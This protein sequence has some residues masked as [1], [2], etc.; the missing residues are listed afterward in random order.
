M[1][2]TGEFTEKEKGKFL[3][4]PIRPEARM[5]IQS[6]KNRHPPKSNC[7]EDKGVQKYRLQGIQ[8]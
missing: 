4:H 1:G 7:E 2:A 8:V 5:P 6:P 3:L